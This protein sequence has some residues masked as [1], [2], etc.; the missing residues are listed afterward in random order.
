ME[1]QP[2]STYYTT[3]CRSHYYHGSTVLLHL[4]FKS[5]TEATKAAVMKG[6]MIEVTFKDGRYTG[7]SIN[8]QI[9]IL[10]THLITVTHEIDLVE[11]I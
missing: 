4:H 9:C 3:S 5:K 10:M 6:F 8:E 1:S 11:R 2:E 7:C